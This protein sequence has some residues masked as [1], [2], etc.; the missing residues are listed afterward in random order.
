MFTPIFIPDKHTRDLRIYVNPMSKMLKFLSFIYFFMFP[1]KSLEKWE[2][3][4]LSCAC[5]CR[6]EKSHP[7][8][9]N[10]TR[11]SASLIPG[12]KSDPSGEISLTYMGTHD[13]LLYSS[14]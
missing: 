2:K 4:K 11:D 12:S 10:I 8:G 7:P 6:I 14:C 1:Q 5:P 9:R 3:N 13:G